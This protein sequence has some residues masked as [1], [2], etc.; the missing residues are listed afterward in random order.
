MGE[1]EDG[2]LGEQNR[3]LRTVLDEIVAS[4]VTSNALTLHGSVER[5]RAAGW[6]ERAGMLRADPQLVDPVVVRSLYGR[7]LA[8]ALYVERAV[9]V[10]VE[11]AVEDSAMLADFDSAL[12]SKSTPRLVDTVVRTVSEMRNGQVNWVLPLLV[13]GVTETAARCSDPELRR[14]FV[15]VIARAAGV[16]EAWVYAVLELADDPS[17]VTGADLA[18]FE[19]HFGEVAAAA[20]VAE[21]YVTTFGLGRDRE[22]AVGEMTGLLCAA[23]DRGTAAALDEYRLV[24]RARS[25]ASSER[26]GPELYS[27]LEDLLGELI[28]GYEA[29]GAVWLLGA[30]LP[31]GRRAMREVPADDSRY[32]E[33]ISAVSSVISDQV[34]RGD[35]PADHMVE[36]LT[37]ARESV[38]LCDEKSP[39]R[40]R[41][42][43]NL[44]YR[45]GVAVETGVL[46]ADSLREAV[47]WLEKAL[48]RTEPGDP[49]LPWRLSR[50]SSHLCQA[51]WAMVMPVEELTTAVRYARAATM[52]VE[53][54]D[55]DRPA[56]VMLECNAISRAIDAG[57]HDADEL[58]DAIRAAEA[59]VMATSDHHPDKIS[60]MANLGSLIAEGWAAG[61]CDQEQL[62]TALSL[63]E[64]ALA[65]T[66]VD[67]PYRASRMDN[68]S[69]RISAAVSSGIVPAAEMIRAMELGYGAVAATEEG[70][71]DRVGFLAN[72]SATLFTAAQ[73][74]IVE[75]DDLWIGAELA[76]HALDGT[77]E[78]Y[79]AL[80]ASRAGTLA[81]LL[82]ELDEG[83]LPEAVERAEDA[84]RLCGA[85]DPDRVLY[86][87]TLSSILV[88]AVRA[89]LVASDRLVEA[90]RLAREAEAVT[91]RGHPEHHIN[92]SN[93]AAVIAE[94]V[95]A[96]I[97]DDVDFG[98]AVDLSLDVLTMLPVSDP[99]RARCVTNLGLILND[100]VLHRTLSEQ[101]AA[102]TMIELIDEFWNWARHGAPSPDQRAHALTVSEG[103]IATAVPLV[104][105][106]AGAR[107][108]IRAAESVRHCLVDARNAPFLPD[109]P[110]HELEV[111]RYRVASAEYSRAQRHFEEDFGDARDTTRAATLLAEAV[112]TIRDIPG[113]SEFGRRPQIQDLIR[114]LNP[115][116]RAIYLVTHSSGGTALILE[117]SGEA[118][119]IELPDLDEATVITQI[120]HLLDSPDN[121]IDTAAWLWIAVAAPLIEK[122]GIDSAWVIVPTAH[123]AMLPLHSAGLVNG[124]WLDHLVEVRTLPT[125]RHLSAVTAPRADGVPTIA[126][127]SAPDLAFLKGD[128]EVTRGFFPD[129]V[130]PIG[131][132][133]TTVDWALNN[134]AETSCAVL[135]G[136]A[137]YDFEDGV[138]LD[139]DDGALTAALLD[140]LPRRRRAIAIVTACS[141]AQVSTTFI[142]ET[143]GL[144]SALLQA[145]FRG[146]C[147]SMWPVDDPVAFVTIGRFLQLH[148]SDPQRAAATVL[149]DV[150]H[151]LHAVTTR[152]L[153][154]WFAELD[155]QIGFSE[156]LSTEF[157]DWLAVHGPRARPLRDPV[158]WAAFAYIGR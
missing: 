19:G 68:L 59:A 73:V 4:E 51:V 91:P 13:Q 63:Q 43:S 36:A 105:A 17:G 104:L 14:A 86:I 103:L 97:V 88:D 49:N 123:T 1:D 108:A 99:D 60:Q 152:D 151:W 69:V 32:A 11:R 27:E 75:Q 53:P 52:L 120:G 26:I 66:E 107:E 129:A 12:R 62:R 74:G 71:P 57:L 55:P 150:R 16:D 23:R 25:L 22:R 5:F 70:H 39:A 130:S 3:R 35:R 147:A 125:L 154:R 133:P 122:L 158:H 40:A 67:S 124:P 144:P 41:F 94:C 48:S 54:D 145:G 30:A 28:S 98:E 148:T 61:R 84:V 80:R 89:G 42:E 121:A 44:G 92:R 37:L 58:V 143:I 46:A 96:G 81:S 131:K 50:L 106:G 114:D 117:P 78:T 113:M 138:C 146:V 119:S 87:S 15:F 149:R 141:S 47:D 9:E 155:D 153:R 135:G 77:P 118:F 142:N 34:D 95:R 102:Q 156:A 127:S 8:A 38:R 110:G 85:E 139:L 112:E 33:V 45:I 115:D 18:R 93:L 137:R 109:L 7:D 6:S 76:R 56:F 90:L 136:H 2:T 100:A 21:N 31:L 82:A 128:C 24:V 29:D 65:G 132:E 101:D 116:T 10:G 111:A 83:Y 79:A 134:L 20:E 140:R 64:A 157:D 72:L 126:M